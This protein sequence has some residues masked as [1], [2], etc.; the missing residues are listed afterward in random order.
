MAGDDASYAIPTASLRNELFHQNYTCPVCK[1]TVEDQ[2]SVSL[3]C[4]G[5]CR[6]GYHQTCA[7]IT[8][9]QYQ[10]LMTNANASWYCNSCKAENQRSVNTTTNANVSMREYPAY[11]A[12]PRGNSGH[13][14]NLKWGNLT[15]F[16][17]INTNLNLAYNEIVKWR[18][19]SFKIPSGAA[20]KSLVEEAGK[21][22]FLYNNKTEWEGLAMKAIIVLLPLTLQKPSKNSKAKHHRE[23]LKR[24][25]DM[26]KD[27]RI[28]E[29]ISEGKQIQN[30]MMSSFKTSAK[31]NITKAFTNMILQGKIS[32]ACKLLNQSNSGPLDLNDSVLQALK[33]KHPKAKPAHTDALAND[34]PRH[35]EPILYEGIDSQVVY[36]AAM[37][38]KGS[39]GPSNIDSD[40]WRQ[41]CCSKLFKPATEGLCEQ[42]A[43][44]ARR[45]CR[46]YVDPNC[47]TE[48]L[49]CRLVPLDKDPTAATLKIRP[50]GIGEVLRRI[51]GKAIMT[52]LKPE[53]TD[54]AGPLQTCAGVQGGIEAVIHAM[55]DIFDNPITE[56]VILVDAENAFNSLNR[57][58]SL[59]NMN[60]ICPEFAKYLINT[61]RNSAHLY[62]S[63]AGGKFILSEEGSTQGDNA[64]MLMYA[65]SI[66]PLI[67]YLGKPSTYENKTTEIPRQIWYADDSGAAGKL[68]SIYT[69][70][71]ELL[72]IGPLLGYNPQPDKCHV[73]VKTQEDY[74]RACELFKDTAVK[75][76]LQGRPYLGSALGTT[77][78]KAAYI[79][80]KIK[81][82]I[83]DIEQLSVIAQTEPHAA[84]HGYI[85][86]ISKKWLY[87]LRTLNI[88]QELLAPLEVAI[89]E[90]FIPA[91]V[92]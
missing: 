47:L 26:W 29:L 20:G 41:L 1:L 11:N 14:R 39:G 21:L 72:K 76:T 33:Q 51:V 24:R 59:L 22:L 78:Y 91:L 71:N 40:I 16:D 84:Y 81:L 82:W 88:S 75:I 67:D 27:G 17:E 18:K 64:A 55:T 86:G 60:V 77:E 92:G 62:I 87:L 48:Y 74:L 66:K 83:A 63:G 73:I 28:S 3:W 90:S 2:Q 15:G 68:N 13:G 53:M 65:C 70:W 31:Q 23:H 79:E 9:V 8:M 44:L 45:L 85:N 35:V 12:A 54:A 56:A 5:I 50:I 89:K 32:A 38:T 36:R 49:A 7:G 42:I 43:V 69:W 46:E 34:T 6:R 25:M 30:R 57:Q 4:D 10:N 80:S 37:Y 19:N 58:A 52:H 61:Y